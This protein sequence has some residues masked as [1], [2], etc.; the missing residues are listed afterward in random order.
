[1]RMRRTS[2]GKTTRVFKGSDGCL[3]V[4]GSLCPMSEVPMAFRLPGR[5]VH[6]HHRITGPSTCRPAAG[7]SAGTA[8]EA[9]HLTCAARGPQVKGNRY[10]D[11]TNILR[12][13]NESAQRL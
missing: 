7:A 13:H 12:Q 2:R 9:I 6:V 5:A 11:A 10:A 3:P 8:M 1:M 4:L